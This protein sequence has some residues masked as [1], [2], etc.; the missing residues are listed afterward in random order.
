MNELL[1]RLGR[2]GLSPHVQVNDI[3]RQRIAICDGRV[4]LERLRDVELT[5]EWVAAW[6]VIDRD[7]GDHRLVLADYPRGWVRRLGLWWQSRRA[8]QRRAA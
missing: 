8:T 6:V 2:W 5:D 1:A 3:E 7:T 4:T